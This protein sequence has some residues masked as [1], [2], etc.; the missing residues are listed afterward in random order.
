MAL[1]HL[2]DNEMQIYLDGNLSSENTWIP[3]HLENCNFCQEQLKQYEN[4][5]A[6]LSNDRDFNLSE[7][8][9]R[10][11]IS[12]LQEE[13]ETFNLQIWYLVLSVVGLIIGVGT[14]LYFT[15]LKPLLDGFTKISEVLKYF[16]LDELS[17]VKNY[18]E[19]LNI[20]FTLLGFALFI[21]I[22]FSA[23]DSFILKA[24]HKI[25]SLMK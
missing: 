19:G 22:I 10:S 15:E 1:R 11:I 2:N 8:F 13:A 4:L 17:V 20:D 14:T 23:I 16:N 7:N 18:V 9:S 5:Y 25:L 3:T 24:K 12:R 21:I 6:A